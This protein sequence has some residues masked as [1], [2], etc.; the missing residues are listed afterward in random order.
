MSKFMRSFL[1]QL[2]VF[3]LSI[4]VDALSK[5]LGSNPNVPLTYIPPPEST[6]SVHEDG[7][8]EVNNLGGTDDPKGPNAPARNRDYI[9]D[10]SRQE[11]TSLRDD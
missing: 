8:M 6:K 11:K 5:R 1:S 7:D 2:A 10:E 9:Y 4:A 3:G